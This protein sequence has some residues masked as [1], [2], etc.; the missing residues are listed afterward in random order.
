MSQTLPLS[1]LSQQ[2][3]N[4][5]L[6]SLKTYF[7]DEGAEQISKVIE[8]INLTKGDLLIKER[9]VANEMYILLSGV[10]EA[11]V[12]T[13]DEEIISVGRIHRGESVG[14][15]AMLG[16]GTRSASIKARRN[17]L[18]IKIDKSVFDEAAAQ[19]TQLMI[20]LSQVIIKRLDKSNKNIKAPKHKSK[21]IS[22]FSLNS[23]LSHNQIINEI[24]EYWGDQS[25]IVVITEEEH[26]SHTQ[27]MFSLLITD[28]EHHDYVFLLSSDNDEWNHRISKNC[29][30][31]VFLAKEPDSAAMKQFIF[32]FDALDPVDELILVYEQERPTYVNLWLE[33]F[34]PNKIFKKRQ[35][36]EPDDHRIARIICE[37]QIC[38][39]LGGGGAHGMA[40][41]GVLKSLFEH[42]IPVDV[43]GG[44]SIG[45]LI[46]ATF[47]MDWNY[48][49]IFQKVKK[50]VSMK[51]PLNDYTLPLVSL[52]KGKKMMRLLKKHFN[53][54]IETT[55][56]NY[57]CVASNLSTTQVELL[58][59]GKLVEGIAA[60]ISIP[61]ILPPRLY[62]NGL[63]IDG[64]VLN[65]LPSDIMAEKYN[66]HIISVDVVATRV[67]T[68]E[69]HYK[70]GNWQFIR[71]KF[72]G[73]KKYVPGTM[74][75][76]MKSSTLSSMSKSAE[77]EAV[78]MYYIK[79][80]IKKG[81]LDWGSMEAF[82]KE[83]YDTTNQTL[84]NHNF[85]KELNIP[86]RHGVID[87]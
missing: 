67:H 44:T 51:N 37:Q 8:L 83:G 84:D 76:I 6:D 20:N 52:L 46:G 82:V 42:G 62:R 39:V 13:L 1:N 48:R 24:K 55:W 5:V 79:P 54:N 35:R 75:T 18:L 73:S 28:L 60:S 64:G 72:F 16:Q 31:R 53:I 77:K 27:E 17:C 19:N 80:R 61:G 23:K 85:Q 40:A 59:D 4:I 78:S 2:Q 50:D 65:N 26:S 57:F 56:K 30:K 29:D 74:N 43:I 47:A 68:I 81:F 21:F 36:H 63:L 32:E 41:I 11:F 69:D 49:S 12:T 15:M 34:P 45:A 86:E 22:L 70:I 10:L 87:Y 58:E 33:L 9:D 25:S 3:R 38:L 66:G 71:N 7:G 14:E